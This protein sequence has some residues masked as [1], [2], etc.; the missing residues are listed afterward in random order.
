MHQIGGKYGRKT[1]Q[2]KL[3]LKQESYIIKAS[4]ASFCFLDFYLLIYKN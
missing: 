4:R 1:F 2:A 3:L